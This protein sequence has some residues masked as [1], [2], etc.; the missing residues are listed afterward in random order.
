MDIINH[1]ILQLDSISYIILCLLLIV[2][3]RSILDTFCQ[4][5]QVIL[6]EI[7]LYCIIQDYS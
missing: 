7:Q 2:K 3:L 6:T 5:P 4:F 1:V